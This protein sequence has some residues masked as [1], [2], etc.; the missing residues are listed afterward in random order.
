MTKEPNDFNLV[1]LCGELTVEPE[2]RAYDSGARLIRFLVATRSTEPLRRLDVVPVVLWDPPDDLWMRDSKR[3]DRVMVI[4]TVQRRYWTA[5]DGRESRVEVVA[6][7]VEFTE[8]M[9]EAA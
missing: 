6:S 1:V 4:G 9:G 5:P 2:Y 3:L 7:N 8:S